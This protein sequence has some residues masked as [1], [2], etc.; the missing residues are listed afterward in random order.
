MR[1]RNKILLIGLAVATLGG[2]AVFPAPAQAR[3]TVVFAVTAP[4]P[5]RRELVPKPRRGHVWAPGHWVWARG[6]YVWRSGTWLRA[7]RGY[8]YVAPRWDR[9]GDRWRYHEG[10]WSH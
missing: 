3:A 5:L 2:G 1:A 7:R 8:V 4:P 9:D 10:R 6:H